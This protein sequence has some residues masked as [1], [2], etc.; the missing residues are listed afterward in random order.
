MNFGHSIKNEKIDDNHY[1]KLFLF[2]FQRSKPIHSFSESTS[3]HYYIEPQFC[4]Q[5]D[6]EFEY[7]FGA[8]AGLQIIHSFDA[9]TALYFGFGT[10]PYYISQSMT[11]QVGGFIF[12][13]NTMLGVKFKRSQNIAFTTQLRMRHISNASLKK[14]NFGIDNLFL[15]FGFEIQTGVFSPF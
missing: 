1:Y 7:E 15:L 6:R 10:G 9:T 4:I 14:P 8:N 5:D 3:L 13:N 11:K 2:A 12:S